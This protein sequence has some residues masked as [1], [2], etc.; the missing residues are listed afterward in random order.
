MNNSPWMPSEEQ[1]RNGFSDELLEELCSS[2]TLSTDQ[3]IYG[4]IPAR[5]W[6]QEIYSFGRCFREVSGWP[7]WLPIPVSLEHGV[8]FG[9]ELSKHEIEFPSLGHVSWSEWKPQRTTPFSAG[10]IIFRATNPWVTYRRKFWPN[11]SPHAFGSLVFLTHSAPGHDRIDNSIADLIESE[12]ALRGEYQPQSIMIAMHDVHLGLHRSL[13]HFGLPILTAGHSSSPFFVDRFYSIIKEFRAGL[14]T[15]PGSHSFYLEE[16]GL[17]FLTVGRG[18]KIPPSIQNAM[19]Q[20]GMEI[21]SYC[22]E[23]FARQDDEFETAKKRL[24]IRALGLGFSSS[25]TKIWFIFILNLPVY[26]V[27]Q[28]YIRVLNRLRRF[29]RGGRNENT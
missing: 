18:E 9:T 25:A 7:K 2:A 22:H 8:P 19:G 11:P 16:M 21:F 27:R 24:L 13:R 1:I 6:P 23:V 20:S 28:S 10:K 4:A 26:I 17:P 15:S 3:A 14:G 12:V 5:Y 29:A